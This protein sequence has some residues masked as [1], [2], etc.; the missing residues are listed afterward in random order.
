[1]ASRKKIA[2]GITEQF[3]ARHRKVRVMGICLLQDCTQPTKG[4]SYY[5]DEHAKELRRAQTLESV[6]RY[7]K[8][9]QKGSYRERY[10]SAEGKPTERALKFYKQTM[11]LLRDGHLK[12]TEAE[13]IAYRQALA[14]ALNHAG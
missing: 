5:C 11:R 10:V 2:K 6:Q 1:M 14:E 7:Y 9:A 12:L 13:N 8:R 3:K 4:K